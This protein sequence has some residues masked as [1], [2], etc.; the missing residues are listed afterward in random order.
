M[1]IGPKSIVAPKFRKKVNQENQ[2]SGFICNLGLNFLCN[3][4]PNDM[5]FKI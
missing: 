3:L 1:Y 2:K 5:T 4:I